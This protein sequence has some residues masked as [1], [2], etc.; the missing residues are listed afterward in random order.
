MNFT[1]AVTVSGN[2]PV[3]PDHLRT[4]KRLLHDFAKSHDVPLPLS[5]EWQ[6]REGIVRFSAKHEGR[7]FTIGAPAAH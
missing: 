7:T 1:D 6:E 4:C 5:A 2:P 3:T